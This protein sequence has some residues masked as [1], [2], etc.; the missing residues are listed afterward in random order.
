[1]FLVYSF[2]LW[3]SLGYSLRHRCFTFKK[4]CTCVN[5]FWSPTHNAYKVGYAYRYLVACL[6]ESML[7]QNNSSFKVQGQCRYL[8]LVFK[9]SS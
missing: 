8:C 6:D 9:Y 5:Y 1:M 2:E 4:L 3:R 7:K